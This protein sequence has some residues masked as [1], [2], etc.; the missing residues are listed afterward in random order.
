MIQWDPKARL[1]RLRNAR[2]GILEFAEPEDDLRAHPLWG[3]ALWV[4]LWVRPG[5]WVDPAK[6]GLGRLD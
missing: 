4:A 5:E 6:I 3:R 1:F 2:G